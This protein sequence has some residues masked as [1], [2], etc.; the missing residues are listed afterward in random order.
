MNEVREIIDQRELDENLVEYYSIKDGRK[1]LSVYNREYVSNDNAT[2][3][4]IDMFDEYSKEELC[5]EH[6]L[7][8]V[9]DELRMLTDIDVQMFESFEHDRFVRWIWMINRTISKAR[10]L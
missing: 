10:K 1:W 2:A 7:D 4:E 6:L 9:Q 3:Y 5:S 8:I